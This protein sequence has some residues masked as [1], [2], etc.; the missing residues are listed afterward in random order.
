MAKKVKAKDKNTKKEKK[1]ENVNYIATGRRKE[2]TARVYLKKGSGKVFINGRRLEVHFPR[3]DHQNMVIAPFKATKTMDKFDIKVK[4]NGGGI[5]GQTGAIVLGVARV[6]EKVNEGHRDVL[7]S[8]GFL[9]R[10]PRVKE[11]K[12][13]GRKRARKSF[14]FSKR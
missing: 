7:K 8:K 12:K 4:V 11:R 5:S 3:E 14:Q 13:Y 1:K 10:D 6:L 9:T 2:S